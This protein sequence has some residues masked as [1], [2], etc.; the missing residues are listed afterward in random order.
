MNYAVSQNSA[1]SRER[2]TRKFSTTPGTRDILPPESRRLRSLQAGIR[3][4]FGRFGFQEVLTPALEYSEVIE[5]PGLRDASFKLFDPDN[6]MLILRPE[7]TTPIARL[8]AQRLSNSPTPHKLSYMLPAFRRASVGRGQSAE[9]YQAGVEVVGSAEAAEDAGVIALLVD[10]LEKAGLEYR[11]YRESPES[12]GSMVSM[13]DFGVALGQSA[14]FEGYLHRAAPDRAA[15]ILEALSAKDLVRVDELS[16]ELPGEVG[17]AVREIPRLVG[18]ASDGGILAAAESYA[19]DA[20]GAREAL[21]NLRSILSH[22]EAHGCLEAVTLDLGLVGRRDYYTGAVF[23][24]YAGGMAF[25][26]A[27]G[28]RYDNLLKRFG[29]SLPATGFAISLERLLSVVP[30]EEPPPLVLLVGGGPDGTR[31]AAKLRGLGVPVLHLAEGGEPDAVAR[32]ARSKEAGWICHPE[33]GGVRISR[34]GEPGSEL[35]GVEEVPEMVLP[36]KV[37]G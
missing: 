22:L 34:T 33:A 23:E 28:G 30:D 25:T 36:G 1:D 3:E 29:E 6:Q 7:A 24:V 37:P 11:A 31:S 5:E 20:P 27:N 21:E 32:Y 8:V 13:P 18:P 16:G 14:F 12:P 19:A 2:A 26:I 4:R 35:V 17:R 9:V 10:V 15:D